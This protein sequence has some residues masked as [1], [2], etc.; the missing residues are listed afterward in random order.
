MGGRVSRQTL[1][2]VNCPQKKEEG[3]SQ[4]EGALTREDIQ[5]DVPGSGERPREIYGL[6]NVINDS[7]CLSGL[8]CDPSSVKGYHT[9]RL[10]LGMLP[11]NF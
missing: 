6:A 9:S 10:E 11:G 4:M 5:Q 7:G 2:D 8:C 1:T 3:P